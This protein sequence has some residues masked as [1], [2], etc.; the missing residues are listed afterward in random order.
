MYENISRDVSA[1]CGCD[2]FG[3]D[4]DVLSKVF[5]DCAKVLLRVGLFN[6]VYIVRLQIA[7]H[8]KSLEVW[9][10]CKSIVDLMQCDA[11]PFDT[12]F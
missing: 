11:L 8:N 7:L 9:R 1:G 4:R 3:L 10:R 2:S 6:L 12:G 5:C